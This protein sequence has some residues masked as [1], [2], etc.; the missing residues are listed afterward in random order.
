MTH[1]TPVV[2]GLILAT[3]LGAWTVFQTW[4]VA[5]G[6][7]QSRGSGFADALPDTPEEAA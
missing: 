2:A 1:R 7:A 6:A 4:P 5:S 3:S